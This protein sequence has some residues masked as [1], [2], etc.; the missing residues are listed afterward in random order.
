MLILCLVCYLAVGNV[1][2]IPEVHATSII[3]VEVHRLVSCCIHIYIAFCFEKEQGK[4]EQSGDWCL[5]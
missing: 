4:R 3:R 1:A 2:E 5:V